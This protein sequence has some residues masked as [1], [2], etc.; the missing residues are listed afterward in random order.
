[1]NEQISESLQNLVEKLTSWLNQI[2]VN[3]PNFILAIL[4]FIFVYWLSRKIQKWLQRPLTRLIN[5]PS[6]R[7]LTIKITSTFLVFLG[8]V[9]ALGILK[10]DTVLSSLLAGAGV[11][12]LAIG[13]ALQ[14]TLSNTFSGIVLSMKDIVGVGDF[15]ETNGYSGSVQEI[16]LRN[17]KIL[18]VDN[19]IIVIP[20]SKVLENPFKNYALTQ[21]I[22]VTINC[23]VDYKSNLRKVKKVSQEVI[24]ERFPQ[25]VNENI[26]FHY[27]EFG[28]S[29]INF[30][31]R[32]WVEATEKLSMLEARSEA[33]MIL[34]ESF[35][36]HNFNIPLPIRT[37]Q[38]DNENSSLNLSL[39]NF[40]KEAK[41][42][43][44]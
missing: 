3:L 34:K 9:L 43:V 5:E 36:E 21:R 20:N 6:I 33:M 8:I 10:L 42:S 40:E 7:L 24:G 38:F 37:L 28:E 19:N 25:R 15:I 30:Q 23:G 16:N 27:L 18:G 22:R 2:I 12:G 31:V 13:L 32:F 35:D 29:A 1:M 41:S 26:E 11:A 44:K 14:G 39:E 17:T 4:V